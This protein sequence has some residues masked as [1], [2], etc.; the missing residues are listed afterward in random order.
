MPTR[1]IAGKAVEFDDEGFMRD[2][3]QWDEAVARA[4][5]SE[6]DIQLTDRHFIVLEFMRNE[7]AVNGKAPSLRKIKNDSGVDTK[8]LYR[9]F[10]KGPAKKAAFIAG[11][12]KPEGCI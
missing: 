9:L 11:L 1:N 8:E 5:A 3:A 2:P 7:Q 4:L 10:P 6:I 12:S